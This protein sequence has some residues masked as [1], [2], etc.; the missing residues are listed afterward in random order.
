MWS[1]GHEYVVKRIHEPFMLDLPIPTGAEKD[2]KAYP[3]FQVHSRIGLPAQFLI[4]L[5]GGGVP[6]TGGF[7]TMPNGEF[8][9]ESVCRPQYLL[10]SPTYKSILKLKPRHLAGDWY[11]LVSFFHGNYG[12]WLWEDLPRLAAALPALPDSVRFLVPETLTSFQKDSLLALGI[13]LDRLTTQGPRTKTVCEKLWFATALGNQD[14]S[15]TA[16]DVLLQMR[17]KLLTA[18]SDPQKRGASRIY[19]SRGSVAKSKRLV[20]EDAVLPVLEDLGFEVVRPELLSLPQ[21]V[22]K[23][24]NCEI[25]L[26]AFGAGLTNMLFCPVPAVILEL[27]DARF[28]PRYWYWK[29]AAT[30]GHDWRCHVG[31]NDA[32]DRASWAQWPSATFKVDLIS[33][34]RF[35]RA[36]L[37]KEADKSPLQWWNENPYVPYPSD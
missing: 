14:W 15:V 22:A 11:S 8:I 19:V 29:I 1:L 28:A 37:A 36:A 25:L 30:I 9:I 34:E 5:P 33:L 21:Q 16:P 10:E 7:A 17:Q 13:S 12:H 32:N 27:Q 20:N 3:V 35:V 4:C 24:Q 26:G 31:E 6:G 18:Y 2:P 23:F